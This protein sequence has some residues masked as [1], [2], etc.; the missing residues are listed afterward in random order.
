MSASELKRYV[1]G[2]MHLDCL[3]GELSPY[4]SLL[5]ALTVYRASF[6]SVSVAALSL[7]IEDNIGLGAACIVNVLSLAD[8]GQLNID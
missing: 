4:A 7:L 3:N 1:L 2:A 8:S 6:Q 5:D